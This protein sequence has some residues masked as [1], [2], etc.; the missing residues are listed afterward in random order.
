MA[1]YLIKSEAFITMWP[2]G[3]HCTRQTL[4]KNPKPRR[5][6]YHR[7]FSYLYEH[8]NRCIGKAAEILA[9]ELDPARLRRD[10]APSFTEELIHY[11]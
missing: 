11:A 1:P 6:R 10:L 2:R 4:F 5:D 7:N 8:K 3:S 9:E